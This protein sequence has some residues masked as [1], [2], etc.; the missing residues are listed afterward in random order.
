MHLTGTIFNVITIIAG[1][2]IGLL[3]GNRLPE[4]IRFTVM[5]GLGLFTM[6]YGIKLFMQTGNAMV[7]LASLLIGIL[8]GEW[9]K[10]E[11]GLTHLGGWF[12]RKFNKNKGAE[13]KRFIQGFLTSSLLFCIG[14]MAILGALQDGLTGDFN[15]LAIKAVIDGF[16]AIAFASSLGIGVLFSSIIVLIYQGSIS[17]FA[18]QMQFLM[19]DVMLNE[20]S[21][22]GG[23]MLIGLAFSSLMEIRKIRVANFLPGFLIVPFMV[24]IFRHFGIY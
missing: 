20:I 3:L 22:L 7:V 17:L 18:N 8:L 21:A 2:F 13:S 15:T 1:G 19:T 10:L 16:S 4:K 12:E 11:D 5:N 9:W 24:L 6:A 23:V 14:P